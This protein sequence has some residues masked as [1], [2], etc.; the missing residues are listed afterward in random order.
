MTI[1]LL[2]QGVDMNNGR[3]LV[4]TDADG[5]VW[6]DLSELPRTKCLDG[7]KKMTS[8]LWVEQVVHQLWMS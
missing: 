6:K 4:I 5:E 7:S 8:K 3:L 2:Q 1:N